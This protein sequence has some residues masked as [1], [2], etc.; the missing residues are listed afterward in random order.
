MKVCVKEDEWVTDQTTDAH[1]GLCLCC[2]HLAKSCF[3]GTPQFFPIS[4]RENL[5]IVNEGKFLLELLSSKMSFGMEIV[6]F[7]VKNQR[8]LYSATQKCQTI[9]L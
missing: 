8:L 5:K 7:M 6:N 9:M 2:L 1:A 3:L 4:V